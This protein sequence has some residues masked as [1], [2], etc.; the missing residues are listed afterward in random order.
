MG[1]IGTL[2]RRTPDYQTA[3]EKAEAALRPQVRKL[4]VIV[5]DPNSEK[6]MDKLNSEGTLCLLHGF[7]TFYSQ[8]Y[9][10]KKPEH[11]L[12]ATLRVFTNLFGEKAST[13]MIQTLQ[14]AM[15]DQA[16]WNYLTEGENA[17]KY[18]EKDGLQLVAAFLGDTD[19]PL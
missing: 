7:I 2:L 13:K 15:R 10:L 3:V 14:T 12:A 9:H 18:F 6:G 19:V 11:K 16:N 1:I 8:K 4:L 5:I 17:A